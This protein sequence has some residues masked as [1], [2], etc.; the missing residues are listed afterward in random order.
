[1][2]PDPGFPPALRRGRDGID[3]RG[4][5]TLW[6]EPSM[7]SL[8]TTPLIISLLIAAWIGGAA[9]GHFDRRRK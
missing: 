6:P 7:C 8:L 2:G 5:A 1:M 3:G 4:G 9:A